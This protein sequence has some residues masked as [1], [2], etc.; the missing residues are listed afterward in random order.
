MTHQLRLYQLDPE[1]V[2]EFV[3]LWRE[4]IIPARKAAGFKIRGAWVSRSDAGFAWVISYTGK[5]TFEDA[6]QRYYNSKA[7]KQMTPPPSELIRD[8]ETVMVDPLV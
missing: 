7:R 5:G 2:E 1:R 4:Q 6:E 3:T 8:I